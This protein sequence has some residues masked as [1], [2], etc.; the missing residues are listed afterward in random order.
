ML[1]IQ[2]FRNGINIYVLGKFKAIIRRPG[3]TLAGH[4]L[5]HLV[6]E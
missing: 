2:V 6:A 4:H 3:V 1:N 5:G